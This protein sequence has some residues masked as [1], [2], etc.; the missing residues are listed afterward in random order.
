MTVSEFGRRP[1]ENESLGT[2]H[3]SAGHTFVFG[4]AVNGNIYGKPLDFS[5]L[6]KN[7]D[8]KYQ[9]DY[10]SI[11]DEL[12][13][14][15]LP[16]Q[17]G[18]SNKILGKKFDY[19]GGGLLE[20]TLSKTVLSTPK[21]LKSV[22]FPNPAVGGVTNLRFQTTEPSLVSLNQINPKGFK[23]PILRDLR[24]EAEVNEIP[25]QLHGGPGLHFIELIKNSEREVIRV[26]WP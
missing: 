10:R 3:G 19:V 18:L 22:V 21:P 6:D 2:D 26:I 23:I 20:T 9:F 12:L 7:K 4:E 11:Y 5:S 14:N 13:S 16:S 1:N 25:V 15:W 17:N 24:F 8:F